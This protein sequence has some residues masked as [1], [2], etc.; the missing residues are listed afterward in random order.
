MDKQVIDQTV[1]LKSTRAMGTQYPGATTIIGLT[2]GRIKGSATIFF[3][4]YGGI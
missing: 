2:T 1:T 4:K 3:G